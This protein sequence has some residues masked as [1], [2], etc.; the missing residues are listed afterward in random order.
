MGIAVWFLFLCLA[1][2]YGY[3]G[4]KKERPIVRP[5]NPVPPVYGQLGTYD[6][7]GDPNDPNYGMYIQLNGTAVFVDIRKDR[8][9]EER[10]RRAFE[11]LENRAALENNL[12]QFIA[13]NPEFR[14]R[15]VKSIGLHSDELDRAEVLWDPDGYTLL[16]GL[17]FV[18]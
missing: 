5:A 13:S 4:F 15:E 8:H 18:S 11:L 9:L 14:N 12:N 10:K 1:T 16:K 2:Y 17:Q 6:V 3:R 7:D